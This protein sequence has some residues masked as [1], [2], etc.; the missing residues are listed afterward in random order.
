MQKLLNAVVAFI[1]AVALTWIPSFAV[2][3]ADAVEYKP[4][5]QFTI[6][7]YGDF[8]QSQSGP[9]YSPGH[10]VHVYYDALRASSENPS[11]PPFG[12]E[13]EVTGY[14][15]SDNS[16]D[17]QPFP[18]VSLDPPAVDFVKFGSFKTPACYEGSDYIEIWFTGT[19]DG[20]VDSD[21]GYN[22]KF[23]VICE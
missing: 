15:M 19:G 8:E 6:A 11:C 4:G 1:V 22:Y 7:P 14:V 3:S 17:F 5:L 20:C 10:E 9:I 13:T 12:P 21:Y 18:L 2:D 16:G 23:P